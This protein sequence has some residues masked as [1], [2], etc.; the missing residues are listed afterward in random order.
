LQSITEFVRKK[1]TKKML[2]NDSD[3]EIA[4]KIYSLNSIPADTRISSI[5][6]TISQYRHDLGV[7]RFLSSGERQKNLEKEA[8]KLLKKYPDDKSIT[9]VN[10][11]LLTDAGKAYKTNTLRFYLREIIN[12]GKIQN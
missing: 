7:G 4:Y 12:Y 3:T 5:R 9:I 10:K 1:V 6:R 2:E 11:L 8:K